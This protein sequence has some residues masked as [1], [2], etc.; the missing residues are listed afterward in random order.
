MSWGKIFS[1]YTGA[2]ILFTF[3]LAFAEYL[4]IIPN[5]GIAYTYLQSSGDRSSLAVGLSLRSTR[6]RRVAEAVASGLATQ[7]EIIAGTGLSQRLVSYH[8][9]RLEK[10]G[11]LLRRDG[12]PGRYEPTDLLRQALGS[13]TPP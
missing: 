2:F 11:A 3:L 1:I 9:R 4:Q 7:A 13:S 8:L 10:A 6:R 5:R 12:R